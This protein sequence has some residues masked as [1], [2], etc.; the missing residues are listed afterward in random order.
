MTQ[1]LKYSG[2]QLPPANVG[3]AISLSWLILATIGRD[4]DLP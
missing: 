3:F 1:K 2:T 4:F